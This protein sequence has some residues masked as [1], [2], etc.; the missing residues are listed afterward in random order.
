VQGPQ[1][2]TAVTISYAG[3]ARCGARAVSGVPDC[4]DG[5]S[6]GTCG[7]RVARAPAFKHSGDANGTTAM[8]KPKFVTCTNK[9]SGPHRR[10]ARRSPRSAGL[11][12][13][14]RARLARSLLQ[15]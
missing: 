11:E 8:E 4:G 2:Q 5:S 15:F 3:A 7:T 1:C 12:S 10:L 9:K 6:Q 13:R 14:L